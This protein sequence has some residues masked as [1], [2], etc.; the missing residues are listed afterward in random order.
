MFPH[1]TRST[2]RLPRDDLE[3]TKRPHDTRRPPRRKETIRRPPRDHHGTSSPPSGDTK[4][5]PGDQG[6]PRDHQ[7]MTPPRDLQRRPTKAH[8]DIRRPPREST[9]VPPGGHPETIRRL[10]RLRIPHTTPCR[11]SH[12][13]GGGNSEA[14]ESPARM[15]SPQAVSNC[16]PPNSGAF[17]QHETFAFPRYFAGSRR[18]LQIHSP[19]YCCDVTLTLQVPTI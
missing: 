1:A 3:T 17:R 10:S 6:T 14:F 12:T 16:F 4:G 11:R 18:T 13:N 9:R 7:Q 5:S 8:H 2:G 15:P 19:K